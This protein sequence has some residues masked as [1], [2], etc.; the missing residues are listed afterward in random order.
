MET[1]HAIMGNPITWQGAAWFTIVCI[2]AVI[3]I[4]LQQILELLR[5]IVG[6]DDD[7][8]NDMP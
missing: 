4:S 6:E 3:S 5:K 1:F 2:L 8:N 7:I